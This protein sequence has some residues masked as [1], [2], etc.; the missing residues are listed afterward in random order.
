KRALLTIRQQQ[1]LPAALGSF[2]QAAARLGV[3]PA[4]GA[5]S[6]QVTGAQIAAVAGMMRHLLREAPI[7]M[8]RVCAA[9][10]ERPGTS[11]GFQRHLQLNV[12]GS[13]L[14]VTQTGKR[15]RILMR[16]G[17]AERP[18]GIQRYN[19]WRNRRPEILCKKRTQ[20]DIFPLLNVA[21]APVV[22]Q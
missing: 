5:G 9:H 20:G 17:D 3:G 8:A 19:P 7:E 10:R 1:W 13:R 22:D 14:R 18:Q 11:L 6:E 16:P 12:V 15:G 21:R 4:D 2:E